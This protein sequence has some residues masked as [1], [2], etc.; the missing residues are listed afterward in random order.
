MRVVVDAS[1]S[2]KWL[3]DEEGTRE[4]RELL[5]SEVLLIAPQLV[6]VEAGNA[7]WKKWLR[8]EITEEHAKEIARTLPQLFDQLY[9]NRSL[10]QRAVDISVELEHPVYDSLYLALCEVENA[11]LVTDDARLLRRLSDS[12]WTGYAHALRKVSDRSG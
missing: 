11:E 10:V 2:T 3:V 6:L 5:A 9:E 12:G 4:A 7:A 1:V 8:G